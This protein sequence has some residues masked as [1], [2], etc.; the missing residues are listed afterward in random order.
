MPTK[1]TGRPRRTAPCWTIV[2]QKLLGVLEQPE[3]P[4]KSLAAICQLAGYGEWAWE[5]AIK[6]HRFVSA[7]QP[8][9]LRFLDPPR[10][11]PTFEPHLQ[12][13]LADNPEEDLAKDVW[14][15]RRL[16]PEYPRHRQAAAFI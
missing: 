11:R 16:L 7:L 8:F 6:D 12:V 15:M 1:R 14:D 13:T 3:H 2:Q 5:R 10:G 4:S 9:K